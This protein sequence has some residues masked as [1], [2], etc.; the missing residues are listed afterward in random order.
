[1]LIV[2]GSDDHYALPLAVTIHSTLS[3]LSRESSVEVLVIDAGI[4]NLSRERIERVTKRARP[5]T[6]LRWVEPEMDQFEAM[7][8][9]HW[10]SPASYLPLLIPTL[11]DD[12]EF[13]VYLDSDILVRDDVMKLWEIGTRDS[14]VPLHAVLDFGFHTLGE[15]LKEN[16]A[17]RLGLDSDAPYFNSG[18]LVINL[19]MWR[20]DAIAIKA[21]EFARSH[22]NVM[23]FTDQDALNAVIQGD[24]GQLDP[25]WNVLIGGIDRFVR[26]STASRA[27]Q[28]ELRK[29][30]MESPRIL[31]FSGPQKPWKPGYTRMGKKEYRNELKTCGWFD[32]E[33]EYRRWGIRVALLSPGVRAKRGV[34]RSIWPLLEKS[35]SMGA[36]LRRTSNES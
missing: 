4:S 16:A 32:D 14:D 5:G 10:G 19:E 27:D 7:R 2:L 21:I 8:T 34:V 15:A 29:S 33:R 20:A 31:H 13:A 35:R 18:I 22:P 17:E 3:R 26:R 12:H 11:V 1:M 9:T 36:R 6:N 24:W 25:G 23:R 30:L 28:E